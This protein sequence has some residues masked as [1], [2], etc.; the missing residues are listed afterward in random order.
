MQQMVRACTLALVVYAAGLV[1]VGG[2]G[3]AILL[4]HGEKD[5]GNGLSYAGKMRAQC[6]AGRYAD[7][8]VTNLF[9]FDDKPSTR[10]V[11][12][13]QPLAAK[14]G[15]RV[16]TQ[17]KRDEI[18]EMGLHI[19]S[20]PTHSLSIV[21]W[22]H[23]RLHTVAEE[24]GV[25]KK[26]IPDDLMNFPVDSYDKQWSIYYDDPSSGKSV[27]IVEERQYCTYGVYYW[28]IDAYYWGIGAGIPIILLLGYIALTCLAAACCG[29]EDRASS[30]LQGEPADEPLLD[31]ARGGL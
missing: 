8:G 2:S 19:L 14:L 21:C 4:R 23:D 3:R 1:P 11:D 6:L 20:L 17:F 18:M 28:G 30:Q 9:A 16:D 26:D 22:E 12:T 31:E 5:G 13:M 29:A 10:P 24:L 25:A 7:A 15:I 27:S